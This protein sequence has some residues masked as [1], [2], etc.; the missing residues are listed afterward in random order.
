VELV[1]YTDA[2][3]WLTEALETDARVMAELGGPWPVER[4]PDIHRRRLEHIARGAW[5]L[6]VVP[7]PG[8]Q[9]V[10]AVGVWHSELNGQ[11]FSEMA[12]MIL[13]EHQGRGHASAAVRQLLERIRADGSWGDVHAFPGATNAPSN[14]ICRKFG[15]E[16]LGEEDVDYGDRTLRCNHW[17]LRAAG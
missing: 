1:P 13:P 14:A 10:G 3:L 8:G 4:I 15:F 7:E 6:K 9:A 12:W 16:L 17:V 5:Y 11:D 2:D